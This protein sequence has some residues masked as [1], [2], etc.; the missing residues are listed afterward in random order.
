LK[1]FIAINEMVDMD[2]RVFISNRRSGEESKTAARQ[3]K[4]LCERQSIAGR[5]G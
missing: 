4:R 5:R 2:A 3:R 1:Q